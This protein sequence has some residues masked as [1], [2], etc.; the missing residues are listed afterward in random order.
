M[1]GIDIDRR[2]LE[3]A[4]WA[5]RQYGLENR[6]S[7]RQMQVYDLAR[8]DEQYDLVLF[9]GVFYHLRYPLLALDVVAQKVKGMM[10]FQ[11]LT[12]PGKDIYQQVDHPI[13]ERASLQESGWPKMAF[14]EY[15]F[16]GDP[17]NWWIPNHA[18]VEAL[19]RSAGM[20]ITGYP[21]HEIYACEPDPDSPSC[22]TTWNRDEHLAALG[23]DM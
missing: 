5:A 23:K 4:Q 17:T 12:M 3:Q 14:I 22:V 9:M 18:G 16:A 8:I 20:R 10:I 15:R 13:N 6:V 2:Y 1:T 21:G 11:T 7:F 19:L